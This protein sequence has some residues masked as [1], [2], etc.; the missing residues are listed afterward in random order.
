MV[1]Y[2]NNFILWENLPNNEENSRD[3]S[4]QRNDHLDVKNK[5]VTELNEL[6]NKYPNKPNLNYLN[7]NPLRKKKLVSEK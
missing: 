2:I 3:S 6:R 5:S 7:I 1:D 4:E